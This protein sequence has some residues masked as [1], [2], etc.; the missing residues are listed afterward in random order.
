MGEYLTVII[1]NKCAKFRK[2]GHLLY[3]NTIQVGITISSLIL[4]TVS[5]IDNNLDFLLNNVIM[6]S[7]TPI[8]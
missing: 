4:L 8:L 2:L 1:I 5:V 6:A 3:V 7:K